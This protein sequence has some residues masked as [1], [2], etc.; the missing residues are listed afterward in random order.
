MSHLT[1]LTRRRML[2]TGVGGLALL[3][4][5]GC[6]RPQGAAQAFDDPSYAYR[7]LS[8]ADRDL[9]AAIAPA[10][11]GN[12]L[13]AATS[14]LSALVQVVR[15]VDVAVAGLPPSVQAEIHQLFGL[16]EFAPTRALAAGVWS[17]WEDA[18][19]AGA[20]AFLTRWRLSGIALFRSG[21]QALHQLVMASWYGNGASWP[22]IGYPGPPHVA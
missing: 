7:A 3:A 9:V 20:S 4:V 21:Y 5:A 6:A 10:M 1:R 18:G 19:E 15:G 14:G 17:S 16:L 13:P 12:A 22:R 2:Q 11:L 8:A